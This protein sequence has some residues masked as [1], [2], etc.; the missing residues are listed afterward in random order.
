MQ[1]RAG[2][3][4]R[5][6]SAAPFLVTALAVQ[7]G[8]KFMPQQGGMPVRLDGH[9]VGALRASGG[10]AARDEQVVRAAVTSTFGPD[11]FRRQFISRRKEPGVKTYLQHMTSTEVGAAQARG[12]TVLLPIGT[13][14]GNGPQLP[15]G[16]DALLAAEVARAATEQTDA[17]WM[18]PLTYGASDDVL[19]LPGTVF[20]EAEL[21]TAQIEAILGS[22]TAG[23]FDHIVLVTNHL[24]N[25]YPAEL[26]CRR[27][28]RRTGV[29][30]PS[31]SPAGAAK[32]AYSNLF[33]EEVATLGHGAEPG[34]SLMQHLL[35]Y[36]VRLDLINPSPTVRSFQGLPYVKGPGV[37]FG[38]PHIA[39]P[40]DLVELSSDGA[41]A[42][43]DGA[44]AE[45][46]RQVFELVVREVIEF[47]TQFHGMDTRARNAG[48]AGLQPTN[49][50]R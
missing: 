38:S 44:S 31:F 35:P 25:L 5:L 20:V 43:P 22:L 49:S 34:T 29:L 19:G 26:A 42:A 4:D 3:K 9:L 28:R 17:I 33:P 45:R 21:L 2:Y 37:N 14:E 36:D 30:V 46:G 13:T 1:T 27:F 10:T 23:G 7:N 12:A 6:Q 39:L 40:V 50:A 32:A 11:A 16:Y 47:L 24:P 48:E 41:F 15:V 18:S 8:G